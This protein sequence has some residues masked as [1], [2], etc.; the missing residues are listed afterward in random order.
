[1]QTPKMRSGVCN[2]GPLTTKQ[3]FLGPTHALVASLDA[4]CTLA[5]R[6]DARAHIA[7]RRTEEGVIERQ[8]KL[9]LHM[10]QQLCCLLPQEVGRPG[11]NE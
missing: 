1:V 5:E 3:Q 9:A 8:A 11:S 2:E 4:G 7:R 6:S 10:P